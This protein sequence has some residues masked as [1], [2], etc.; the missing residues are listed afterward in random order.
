MDYIVNLI[1]E[2]EKLLMTSSGCMV[3]YIL[4]SKEPIIQR[5]MHGLCGFLAALIFS[6]PI[7]TFLSSPDDA[8]IYAAAIALCGQFIPELLQSTIRKVAS[9]NIVEKLITFISGGKK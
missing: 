1:I 5:I 2:N 6:K 7:A 4:L 8:H 3:L 9:A